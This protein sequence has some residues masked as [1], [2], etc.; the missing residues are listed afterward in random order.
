MSIVIATATPTVAYQLLSKSLYSPSSMPK[1][2][3]CSCRHGLGH[4]NRSPFKCNLIS[5]VVVVEVR[6]SPEPQ[7]E[8]PTCSDTFSWGGE[9]A[10]TFCSRNL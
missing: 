10:N 9:T 1:S 6:Y 8:I 2:C 4:V 3:E 7:S 5:S